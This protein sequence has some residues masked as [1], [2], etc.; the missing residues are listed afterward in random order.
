FCEMSS[1]SRSMLWNNDVKLKSTWDLSLQ[2]RFVIYQFMRNVQDSPAD[3]WEE[4][5][6]GF[7][8]AYDSL[9]SSWQKVKEHMAQE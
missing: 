2:I 3:A 7:A 5:K 6:K 8:E 4:T 9:S 1:R